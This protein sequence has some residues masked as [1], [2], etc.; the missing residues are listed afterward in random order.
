[1]GAGHKTRATASTAGVES[2][3]ACPG[4]LGTAIVHRACIDY[5]M[6]L[7]GRTHHGH[8]SI[9]STAEIEQFFRSR[10]FGVICGADGEA[11]LAALRRKH[12]QG[13]KTIYYTVHPDERKGVNSNEQKRKRA[14]IDR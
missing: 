2:V 5:L 8:S 7:R 9:G 14:C 6:L 3:D 4:D 10:W 12:R 11:I 1:M 13:I